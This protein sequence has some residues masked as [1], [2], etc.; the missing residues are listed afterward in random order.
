MRGFLLVSIDLLAT[1]SLETEESVESFIGLGQ[2]NAVCNNKDDDC[3][4]KLTF[5]PGGPI[6]P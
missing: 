6:G 1:Y 3:R 5:S 2:K 4:G